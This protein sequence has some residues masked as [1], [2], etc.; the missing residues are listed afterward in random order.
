MESC[1][2]MLSTFSYARCSF[3]KELLLRR[4]KAKVLFF[5]IGC[6]FFLKKRTLKLAMLVFSI[7][8]KTKNHHNIPML[9]NLIRIVCMTTFAQSNASR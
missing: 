3:R 2:K 4:V 5:L 7:Q 6:F 8:M 1:G 9:G